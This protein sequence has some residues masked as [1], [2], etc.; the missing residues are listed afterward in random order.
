MN[1]HSYMRELDCFAEFTRQEGAL[2]V[3][4]Y[5]PPPGAHVQTI[6]LETP[7]RAV[8]RYPAGDLLY[9][10]R[11]LEGGRRIGR[12]WRGGGLAIYQG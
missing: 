3:A 10:G 7:S 1:I 2:A 6:C 11:I 9:M 5:N 4:V 12:D 8:L